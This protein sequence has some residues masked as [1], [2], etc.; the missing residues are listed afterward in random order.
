LRY[1]AAVLPSRPV[2]LGLPTLERWLHWVARIAVRADPLRGTVLGVPFVQ[3]FPVFVHLKDI[4]EDRKDL[5][6]RRAERHE[7]R[8]VVD[9]LQ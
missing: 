5:L 1:F 8:P 7:L 2:Q 9:P 4:G 6:Q 3:D